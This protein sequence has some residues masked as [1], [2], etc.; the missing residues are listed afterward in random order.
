M[1]GVLVLMGLLVV[2]L[3]VYRLMR[4]RLGSPQATVHSLLRHYH[5]FANAGLPEQEMLL[6]VLIGR[7][8]WKNLPPAFLAEIVTRLR[9]KENV[10]RFV[11]LAEGYRFDQQRLPAIATKNDLE[12]GMR[13]IALWLVDFGSRMQKDN[14]LKEAEF[15]QNLALGLQPDQYFTKLPLASTYYKMGRYADALPL[16]KEGLATTTGG[17]FDTRLNE[18]RAAYED[19]Y[20]ACLPGRD[21][22]ESP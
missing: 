1:E 13:E 6:R 9:S 4:R 21:T 3:A 19:M 12:E 10:F 18:T 20:K 8:G 5:S 16:F 15:V 17:E 11:S 7:S 22:Q 14:R 2:A